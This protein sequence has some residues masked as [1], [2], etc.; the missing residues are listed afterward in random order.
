MFLCHVSTVKPFGPQLFQ[1]KPRP[2][3][4]GHGLY[5]LCSVPQVE[6]GLLGFASGLIVLA[7]AISMMQLRWYPL[8][9]I[10]SVLAMIPVVSP[11]CL[12]GLPFGIWSL[13]VLMQPDVRQSFS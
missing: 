1:L 13:I 7:G 11:C 6:L 4:G 2:P 8:A 3:D 10:A 5:D 9:I 12:L